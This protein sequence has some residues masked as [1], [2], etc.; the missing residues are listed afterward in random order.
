ME[1]Q[2][3]GEEREREEH[4]N[5]VLSGGEREERVRLVKGE[6]GLRGPPGMTVRGPP[7]NLQ[8]CQSNSRSLTRLS[9][10]LQVTYNTVRSPPGNL[11]DRQ[12][13]SRELTRL[14]EP[15]QVTYMTVKSPPGTLKDCQE[16][17]R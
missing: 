6:R 17:S 3:A 11:H 2:L 4:E 9:E 10:P 8:D 13:P 12:R 5:S 14:S 16:S 1:L 7:G 15:L